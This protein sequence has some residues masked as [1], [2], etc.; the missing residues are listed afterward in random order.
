M[1][2]IHRTPADDFTGLAELCNDTKDCY[3]VL[4]GGVFTKEQFMEVKKLD[5]HVKWI[6]SKRPF[7]E[8]R[9]EIEG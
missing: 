6:I 5:P 8:V 9:K 7:E 4:T 3:L 1:T 2:I